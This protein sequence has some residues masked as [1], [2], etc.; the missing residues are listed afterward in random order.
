MSEG[1]KLVIIKLVIVWTRI[2]ARMTIT[3]AWSQPVWKK[4]LVSQS[5]RRKATN[6]PTIEPKRSPAPIKFRIPIKLMAREALKEDLSPAT[7]LTAIY[8]TVDMISQAAINHVIRERKRSST[9]VI[10]PDNPDD[11]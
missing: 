11:T 5:H 3:K 6:R 4:D 1:I 9:P 2:K 8:I 7:I 10:N